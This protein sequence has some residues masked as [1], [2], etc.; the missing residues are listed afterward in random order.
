MHTYSLILLYADLMFF[1]GWAASARWAVPANRPAP[2][3][4]NPVKEMTR[5]NRARW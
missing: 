5:R 1:M 3:R 4:S 2:L